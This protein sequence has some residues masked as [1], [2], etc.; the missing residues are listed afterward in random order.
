MSANTGTI[1]VKFLPGVRVGQVLLTAA[2]VASFLLG[3][4]LGWVIA[5]TGTERPVNSRDFA[6]Y[7]CTGHVP[8]LACLKATWVV[9]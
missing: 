9:E 2:L 7:A 1:Q 3:V 4:A 6:Q 5:P 8:T